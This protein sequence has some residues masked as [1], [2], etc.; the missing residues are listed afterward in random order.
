[1]RQRSVWKMLLGIERAVV[2]DVRVELET[3]V[4][5]VRAKSRE[6]HRCG[7]CGRRCPRE[8]CGEG[9]RRWRALDLGTTFAYLEADAPRVYCK[10]HR[11]VVAAVPWA[12]H[13]SRFT[14]AFE[15]Q[16]AWLAV[17]TSKKA[18]AE[19]MRV[20]WRTV[21]S[22]CERVAAEAIASRDLFADLKRIGIDDFSHRKG[23]RYLT[24]VVDHDSGRLLWAAPGR[25]RKT[26]EKFLDL[27]GKERCEQLELVSCDMAESIALA[28]GERCP[29]A[30]RC[31][32]PFH[33]IKLAT[34]AL[35]EIRREVWNEARRGGHKQVA[36]ELKGARFALWKNPGRLTERQQLKLAQIQ[37]TNKPLYRAYLISQQLRE[38][39]RV[40]Y[41]QAVELL[42]AWLAWAR[43]CRL[44]PF[45][46]LAKTITNQRP[47]IEAAIRHGLSNARIEQVNTQLRLITR[48]AY[49]FRTP[50]ALIALA[51]L[52][53]GGLC[54]PLPQ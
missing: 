6:K 9:R 29:N 32:D 2:E 1:M 28:V 10:R 24:V 53:L 8:D 44:A 54:P 13:D 14:V 50:Q 18:V 26:V 30:V 40:T 39:Y 7:V 15:D 36:T 11:V 45:V 12:R 17:N 41:E 52:S 23:H 43:R 46:K 34:D 47:G 19:L 25:D 38:I 48:R 5:S 42:D 16:C 33:V 49:G 35:D 3:I 4:V 31:V 22:I 20:T 21:G 37:Q 27:L 51:M